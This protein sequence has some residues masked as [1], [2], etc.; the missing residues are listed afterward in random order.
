MSAAVERRSTSPADCVKL[1]YTLP[2][3]WIKASDVASVALFA[4][5]VRDHLGKGGL[6]VI[7]THVDLGLPEATIL[8]L[9]P[10]RARVI[11]STGFDEA[12]A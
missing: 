10:Y 11:Q 2:T 6:A 12:F 5:V 8:D 9:D 7:A 4:D 3:C 1:T